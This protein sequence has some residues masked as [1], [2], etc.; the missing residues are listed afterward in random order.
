VSGWAALAFFASA[1]SAR[2]RF[3]SSFS[4]VLSASNTESFWSRS[5]SP[6]SSFWSWSS[7]S[8]AMGTAIAIA[9]VRSLA[10]P[11]C[12][13]SRVL[14]VSR[15]ISRSWKAP[16][17]SKTA[18]AMSS[19]P[20]MAR[21]NRTPVKVPMAAP[22]VLPIKLEINP[23]GPESIPRAEPK[24]DDKLPP[25]LVIWD[26]VDFVDCTARACPDKY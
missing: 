23:R 18:P 9:E 11:L 24:E 5:R 25:A 2:S 14:R 7:R 8:P 3:S 4:A 12:R 17:L 16:T 22:I 19:S 10:A 20:A 15:P 6:A 21:G 26:A 13:S 1:T